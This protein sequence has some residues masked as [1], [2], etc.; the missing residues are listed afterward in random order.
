VLNQVRAHDDCS[1]GGC[2]EAG[3]VGGDVLNGV[4]RH[5]RGIYLDCG[6]RCAV[7]ERANTEVEV[8]FR[9]G[10]SSRE[11]QRSRIY[12]GRSASLPAG[13]AG[14]LADAAYCAVVV[15]AVATLGSMTTVGDDAESA[16]RTMTVFV[17][18]A[19]RPVWAVATY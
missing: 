15:A 16:A 1:C 8:G 7:Q 2:G 10:R 3:L 6:D 9:A 18:V 17:E 4:G 11:C 12:R 5:L 14:W 19:V 13:L